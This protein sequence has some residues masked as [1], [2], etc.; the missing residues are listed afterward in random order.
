MPLISWKPEYTV[1][2]EELDSHH[3]QLFDLLNMVYDHVMNS[4]E[5]DFVLPMIEKLSDFMIYHFS[6]EENRMRENRIPEIDAHIA[7]HREFTNTI[8]IL[9]THYNGNNLEIAQELIILL[10][11][12]LLSHVLLED[13]KYSEVSLGIE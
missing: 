11:N 1:N 2:N 13:K 6:A 4:L 8:E 10:G 12:W 5:V 9:K 3:Q 7:K